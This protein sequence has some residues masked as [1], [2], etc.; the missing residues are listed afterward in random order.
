M[1]TGVYLLL[2]VF[3]DVV[4]ADLPTYN[5]YLSEIIRRERIGT[6]PRSY[7]PSGSVW[8]FSHWFLLV[9]IA[10]ATSRMSYLLTPVG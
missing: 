8:V 9:S 7:R 10:L 1:K 6:E 5:A 3:I 4:V 2:V